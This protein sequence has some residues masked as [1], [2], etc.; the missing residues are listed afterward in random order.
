MSLFSRL[1]T[2]LFAFHPPR[3]RRLRVRP[4]GCLDLT[5]CEVL[6]TPELPVAYCAEKVAVSRA[7]P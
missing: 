7:T 6:C 2:A 4:D 3:L 1:L 5:A